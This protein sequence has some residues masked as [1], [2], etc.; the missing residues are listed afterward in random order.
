MTVVL[1]KIDRFALE[2]K[3]PPADAY[4]KI[5]HTLDEINSIIKEASSHLPDSDLY[6]VSP[7]RSNVAFA[8]G[9]YGFIFTIASFAKKY[10]ESFKMDKEL[11]AKLLWGDYYLNQKTRKF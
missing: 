7:S 10:E 4:L 3:I 9:K 5:K 2:L 11:F 8:S 6:L 1:S